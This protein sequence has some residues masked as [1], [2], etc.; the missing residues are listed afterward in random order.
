MGIKDVNENLGIVAEGL[1]EMEEHVLTALRGFD[2]A[3]KV[4]GDIANT[5]ANWGVVLHLLKE[6]H[7]T[8]QE[9]IAAFNEKVWSNVTAAQKH[10]EKADIA[11]VRDESEA[12]A[13]AMEASDNFKAENLEL[14][15]MSAALGNISLEI[16]EKRA[17]AFDAVRV[18]HGASGALIIDPGS[19]F[20]LLTGISGMRQNLASHLAEEY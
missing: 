15:E 9:G 2:R 10:M 4:T 8:Y 3:Y 1:E 19:L 17:A 5:L 11:A 12:A 20:H 14:A 13:K 6:S 7:G 18:A 16:R